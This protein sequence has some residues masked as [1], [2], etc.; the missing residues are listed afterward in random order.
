MIKL[1]TSYFY[2]LTFALLFCFQCFVIPVSSKFVVVGSI[3]M[4]LTFG[5]LLLANYKIFF[6]TIIQFLKNNYVKLYIFFIIWTICSGFILILLQKTTFKITGGHILTGLIYS[7]FLPL[8]FGFLFTKKITPQKTIQILYLLIYGMLLFGLFDFLIFSLN[9]MPLKQIYWFFVN[10]QHLRSDSL[11]RTILL[12]GVPRVRSTF[13]EPCVWGYFL[14]IMM[15]LIYYFASFK[16]MLLKNSFIKIIIK[17]TYILL[18]WFNIIFSFSPISIGM[19]VFSTIVYFVYTKKDNIKKSLY[20][21]ITILLFIVLLF[22]IAKDTEIGEKILSRMAAIIYLFSDFDKLVEIEPS[23]ATRLV[24]YINCFLIGLKNILFGVGWGHLGLSLNSQLNVSPVTLTPENIEIFFIKGPDTTSFV[25]SF[26]CSI[27]GA[28]G[29]LGIIIFY[30]FVFKMIY[31]LHK[32]KQ[33][34]CKQISQLF[35]VYEAYLV[36]FIVFSFYESYVYFQ[37]YWIMF[38]IIAY[39]ITYYTKLLKIRRV[40]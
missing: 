38:G 1:K 35:S 18:A 33:K 14:A 30:S 22:I 15:P 3:L 6:N 20:Y 9:I 34:F 27:F 40:E 13:Q 16:S 37:Y 29:M 21:L 4:L 19:S 12:Y 17:R 10:A 39:T 36:L 31:T 2:L 28:T 8:F 24:Y 26:A 32:Y 5:I 7:T 25:E 23:L 11:P